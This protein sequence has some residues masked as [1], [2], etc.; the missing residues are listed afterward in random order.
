MSTSDADK[1]TATEKITYSLNTEHRTFTFPSAL[2]LVTYDDE[3]FVG[4][5]GGYLAPDDF[6]VYVQELLGKSAKEMVEWG[7]EGES[8][9]RKIAGILGGVS[10][11]VIG[12]M[13]NH[14]SLRALANQIA[15]VRKKM[16]ADP[17]YFSISKDQDLKI[18]IPEPFSEG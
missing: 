8:I 5:Y 9:W 13:A 18:I 17:N 2:I 11:G 12:A 16:D 4:I 3:A 14:P 1:A 7:L 10:I 6:R 15:L